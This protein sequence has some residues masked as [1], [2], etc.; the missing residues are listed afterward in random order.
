MV[1]YQDLF[2]QRRQSGLEASISVSLGMQ[3]FKNSAEGPIML[4]LANRA[5]GLPSYLSDKSFNIAT[6]YFTWLKRATLAN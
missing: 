5:C 3:Q 6:H 1:S 2:D 4:N